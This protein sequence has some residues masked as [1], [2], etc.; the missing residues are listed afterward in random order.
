MGVRVFAIEGKLE[1]LR[2]EEIVWR[3]SG[4]V[5]DHVGWGLCW[6]LGEKGKWRGTKVDKARDG[7]RRRKRGSTLRLGRRTVLLMHC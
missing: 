3:Q 6:L 2:K 7:Q 4:G 1:P 5:A